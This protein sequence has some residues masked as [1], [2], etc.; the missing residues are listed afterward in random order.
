M[1]RHRLGERQDHRAEPQDRASAR[2][3][4]SHRPAV[5]RN[6]GR[7]WRTP[8]IRPSR[9]AKYVIN[10][11]RGDNQ[12]LRTQ[13]ERILRRAGV[14]AWERLFHNL[15]GSRE[16]ELT[17]QFPLHVVCGWIGNS[18]LIAARHYLQVTDD[19]FAKAVA[20]T[21]EGLVSGE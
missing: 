6:C 11:Y 5:S 15:R 18:A 4:L 2:R 16:T 20:G 1:G 14:R 19:H 12:N 10:R 21:P 9:A 17:E 3:R 8:S 13:F 7:T